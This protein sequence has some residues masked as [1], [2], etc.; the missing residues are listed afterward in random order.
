MCIWATSL[1]ACLIIYVIKRW[2]RA[3]GVS[4]G[5]RHGIGAG[6]GLYTLGFLSRPACTVVALTG[7]ERYYYGD[8]EA[9][10]VSNVL[11]A[12]QPYST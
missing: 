10:L 9:P 5:Y 8:Q 11:D 12:C 7:V 6:M 3:G 2:A 4:A 1:Q